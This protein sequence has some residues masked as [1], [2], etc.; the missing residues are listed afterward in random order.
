MDKQQ[1]FPFKTLLGS[2]ASILSLTLWLSNG[3]DSLNRIQLGIL[4][5]GGLFIL[6]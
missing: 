2:N 5:F 6:G 1:V 4:A 3:I